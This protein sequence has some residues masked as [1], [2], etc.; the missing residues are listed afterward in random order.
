MP[1]DPY[2]QDQLDRFALL[3]EAIYAAVP[4]RTTATLTINYRPDLTGKV[5]L[6]WNPAATGTEAADAQAVI[7]GWAW[8]ARRPRRIY[9]IYTDISALTTTQQ[10]A[11]WTDITSGTPPKWSQ[12]EGTNAGAIAAIHWSAANSG[13]GAAAVADAKRRLVACYCQD[14]ARYLVHPAFDT[15]INIA[16]DEPDV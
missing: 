5:L 12:D 6:Q 15:N 2:S 13:A 14:N 7:D 9:D 10:N 8:E 4:T 11:V 16:G 3:A 1:V